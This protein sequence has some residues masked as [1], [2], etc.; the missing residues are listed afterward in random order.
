MGTAHGTG[1]G[2]LHRLVSGKEAAR[3]LN[4]E[5]VAAGCHARCPPTSAS[6]VPGLA[7]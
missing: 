2:K 6:H 3:A 5:R 1:S 4:G 7:P